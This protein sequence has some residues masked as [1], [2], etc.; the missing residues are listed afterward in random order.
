M[1]VLTIYFL[2]DLPRLQRSV[3]LLFPRVHGD[4]FARIADVMVDKVGSYMIGNTA[5]SVIAGVAAFAAFTAL[6]V[7]FAVPLAFLS[8]PPRWRCSPCSSCPWPWPSSCSCGASSGGSPRR[9]PPASWPP[10]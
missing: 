6:G 9:R 7:P 4:R 5:I 8:W 10:P 1:A 2:A 3:V